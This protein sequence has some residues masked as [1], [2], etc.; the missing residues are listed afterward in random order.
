MGT[1]GDE[2]VQLLYRYQKAFAH[3]EKIELDD[4]FITREGERL[5]AQ[6]KLNVHIGEQRDDEGDPS[7]RYAS[8]AE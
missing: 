8:V 6:T 3:L 5:L 1:L 7:N 4:N 2:G